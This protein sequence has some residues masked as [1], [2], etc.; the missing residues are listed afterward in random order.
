MRR[1]LIG[2][3]NT[4]RRDD[5]VGPAV[6]AEVA[7]LGVDELDVVS[8]PGEPTAILDAWTGARVAVVVDAAL[9]ADSSPGRIRRW[10]PG[11]FA[12]SPATSSHG[13]GLAQT[14]EL[15]RALDR[16]PGSVVVVTVDIVD[17]GLGL[18]LSA[19]VAAAVPHAVSAVLAEFGINR[20]GDL[21]PTTGD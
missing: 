9:G 17:A 14:Y 12:A 2:V 21:R 1:L 6:A 4:F 3:G 15:G 8:V 5:G 7:R 19:P 20:R 10:T 11:A 13:F 16:L 18:G